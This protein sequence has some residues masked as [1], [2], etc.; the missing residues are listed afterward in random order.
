MS[1]KILVVEDEIPLAK[2]FARILTE[3]DYRPSLAY[4]AED[5]VHLALTD[6][7]DLILLDVMIPNMGGLEACRR[8]RKTTDKPIV[9]LTAM[10]SVENVVAG[11]DMGADDYLVKPVE[12]AELLAR[13]KAHLR[14]VQQA[15]PP[16]TSLSFGQNELVIDFSKHIV[17]VKGVDAELTAREFD[18]LTVLALNAGQ[19]ITTADLTRQAWG[20]D[21]YS[22]LEGTKTYIHYIRKKI[23]ADPARPHWIQTVRGVGYRMKEG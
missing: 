11:L 13:I 16:A 20:I 4:T 1:A 10:G 17:T 2:A 7:F 22:A 9:F 8:I 12:Q 6:S 18:L 5:G 23:E 21:D 14:R 3:A 15:S 19:V